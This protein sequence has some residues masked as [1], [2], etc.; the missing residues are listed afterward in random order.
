MKLLKYSL[1]LANAYFLIH[2]AVVGSPL[3]LVSLIGLIAASTINTE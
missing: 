1:I 2:W 3:A